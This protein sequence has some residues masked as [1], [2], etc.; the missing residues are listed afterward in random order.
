MLRPPLSCLLVAA[1]VG[2]K[3]AP[4]RAVSAD[5]STSVP[6]AVS[7]SATPSLAVDAPPPD[8]SVA[9]PSAAAVGT[10][11][12][13]PSQPCLRREPA[14]DGHCSGRKP[15]FFVWDEHAC[16]IA[17]TTASEVAKRCDAIG[18]H[19]GMNVLNWCCP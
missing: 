7:P 9:A 12:S 13:G 17:D 14:N 19:R 5:A 11:V 6:E 2:C 18:P 3:P 8:A 10:R 4:S 15:H 16:A 1:A